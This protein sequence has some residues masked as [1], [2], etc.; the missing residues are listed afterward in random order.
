MLA[1]FPP[2]LRYAVS[3]ERSQTNISN[4]KDGC[5]KKQFRAIAA[6]G[7]FQIFKATNAQIYLLSSK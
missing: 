1:V 3:L 4:V 5:F 2:V 7:I 6:V